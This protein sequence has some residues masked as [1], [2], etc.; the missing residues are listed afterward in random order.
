M[1][2]SWPSWMGGRWRERLS[3]R[4]RAVD[5]AATLA[6]LGCA[7][8]GSLVGADESVELRVMTF[9]VWTVEDT[10]AGRQGIINT[11]QQAGADLVGFQEMG[12]SALRSIA[13]TMG[14][15]YY[16][17]GMG[18]EAILSRYPIVAAAPNRYGALIELAPGHEAWLFNT[19]LFHAPYGPYQ[20][21]GITY[22]GGKL[23]DPAVP[24]NIPLVIRDQV[25]ARGAEVAAIVRSAGNA[26]ALNGER[27][28][29]LT[30]DFNEPSHLDWTPAAVA[31]GVHVAAVEWPTS[32]V[33]ADAGFQDSWRELYPDVAA[34]PG[35]TWSP[36]YPSTYMNRGD[37]PRQQTGPISEPQDRID[38]VYYQGSNVSPIRSARSGPEGGNVT[39]EWEIA[40]YPSD[41][42]SVTTSFSVSGLSDTTMTFRTLQ[43]DGT[44]IPPAYGSRSLS[45]PNIV[46]SLSAEGGSESLPAVWRY[47][48]ATD[49]TNELAWLDPGDS[50][51]NL[52]DFRVTLTPDAG[53][54]VVLDGM[55]LVHFGDS[56]LAQSVQWGLYRGESLLSSGTVA[57]LKG[58]RIH[59]DPGLSVP[60][61]ESL[62]LRLVPQLGASSVAIDNLRFRQIPE[63]SSYF[64]GLLATLAALIRHKSHRSH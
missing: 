12:S 16:D 22:N 57:L 58:E 49:D 7:F 33:F 60:F 5:A 1:R 14:F 43:K 55:E 13:S 46:A 39:E 56:D 15:H 28:V 21:N 26:D 6:A 59:L 62:E 8:A 63:P 35:R 64:V 25:S 51:E 4:N 27:P 44:P 29:F 45:S 32:K 3:M 40:R 11:I 37:N 19:H 47:E 38:I 36:V 61:A 41:H 2:P 54:A 31:A 17:Q 50:T 20:L 48:R 10:T 23:Y 34:A 18:S 24:E 42:N 53:H 52:A 30:G 9:N